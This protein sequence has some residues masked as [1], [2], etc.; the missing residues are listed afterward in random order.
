MNSERSFLLHKAL[1][2]KAFS[3]K[4]RRVYNTLRKKD[5]L[6]P[7]LITASFEA[8]GFEKTRFDVFDGCMYVI[9]S[10]SLNE[11]FLFMFF[12]VFDGCIDKKAF[13]EQTANYIYAFEESVKK[14][15]YT[16]LNYYQ[17]HGLCLELQEASRKGCF[18]YL[19]LKKYFI[20]VNLK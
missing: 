20:G 14:L 2:I 12:D 15:K 9:A 18:E 3:L 6:T 8:V 10:D 13:Y 5:K 4:L 19:D 7:D 11:T 17:I 16:C 1:K